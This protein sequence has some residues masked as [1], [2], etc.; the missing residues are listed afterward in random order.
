MTET[1]LQVLLDALTQLTRDA[2]CAETKVL[3]AARLSLR[4]AMPGCTLSLVAEGPGTE[5]AERLC[6]A[7]RADAAGG[8]WL[9]A[10]APPEKPFDTT[11]IAALRHAAALL[12][13]LLTLPER[14]FEQLAETEKLAMIGRTVAAVAHELNGPLQTIVSQAETLAGSNDV[15]Q[16]ISAQ[17]ILRSGL[18][19]SG[20]VQDL[21]AFG[22]PRPAS[23]LPTNLHNCVLEALELDRWS[24]VGDVQVFLDEYEGLPPVV[25]DS[26]RLVQVFTNL[27]ANARQASAA[28]GT[29]EPVRVTLQAAG[30]ELVRA[31]VSD[32]GTGVPSA[33]RTRLFEPFV[34][35][36]QGGHGLGL[37]LSQRILEECG[38]S[39]RLDD[40]WSPGA[41]FIVELRV[42]TSSTA[43]STVHDTPLAGVRVLV[44]DDDRELLDTYESLL[45]LD[46]H[47]VRTCDRAS[48]AL[49][50]LAT[51]DFDAIL[52]DLRLPD[53]TGDK[54]YALLKTTRPELA[55]R[56][57]FASGDVGRSESVA[58]LASTQN[59]VL[60][61]PFRAEE[62]A[63]AI[64]SV[65]ILP[66]S[67]TH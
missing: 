9:L 3:D 64:H 7:V 25:A 48:L 32:R 55:A 30:P 23:H 22:S 52:C 38:G 24:D 1:R 20:I 28:A 63:R 34:S 62:L 21:L 19:C 39:L 17:R 37:W 40:G 36:R 54:F 4:S 13:T 33:L 8:I 47:H 49:D 14:L 50:I 11:E 45:A 60:L 53:M 67:S 15:N 16:E 46:G 59:P 31:S 18:R 65:A 41:R 66:R 56:I 27:F 10:S 6:L 61:K 51:E 35:S 29:R 43:P 12:G 57:I 58:F 2:A 5:S 42:C 26:A 44:I